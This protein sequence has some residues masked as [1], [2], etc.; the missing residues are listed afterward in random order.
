MGIPS[1]NLNIQGTAEQQM[2]FSHKLLTKL[3]ELNTEFVIWW[4]IQDMNQSALKIYQ[5][6][7]HHLAAFL[8]KDI[9]LYDDYGNKRPSINI[10]DKWL[11][12]P[13]K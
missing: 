4:S 11:M 6:A 9:G 2:R 7:G 1:I 10:W 5:D 8:W 3:N 13:K 12:L